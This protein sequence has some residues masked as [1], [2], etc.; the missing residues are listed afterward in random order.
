MVC[1]QEPPL[2]N[3]RAPK[4]ATK[5]QI[6]TVQEAGNPSHRCKIVKTWRTAEGI[7]AYQ[8][9]ALDTGEMMTIVESGPDRILKGSQPGTRSHAIKMR[10]FHW[11]NDSIPP[12]GSPVPP[13]Q[14]SKTPGL[15]DSQITSDPG[16]S[17]QKP[18]TVCASK[19]TMLEPAKP[20]KRDQNKI[21]LTRPF[22]I[23]STATTAGSANKSTATVASQSAGSNYA[24][25]PSE[26]S[27]SQSSWIPRFTPP[28]APSTKTCETTTVPASMPGVA[29]VA[30]S[31]VP[32]FDTSAEVKPPILSDC[33]PSQSTWMPQFLPPKTAKTCET[34]VTVPAPVSSPVPTVTSTASFDAPKCAINAE[35][36]PPISSTVAIAKPAAAI[37][38]P[39]AFATGSNANVFIPTNPPQTT[40]SL[41]PPVSFNKQ[42]DS[43]PAKLSMPALVKTEEPK[44]V[45]VSAA[46]KKALPE[47]IIKTAAPAI[48][49]KQTDPLQNPAGYTDIPKEMAR[50]ESTCIPEPDR[51][52]WFARWREQ[53]ETAKATQISTEE[54][55]TSEKV[56]TIIVENQEAAPRGALRRLLAAKSKVMETPN[57]KET[58]STTDVAEGEIPIPPV[59]L[60]DTSKA[61]KP[62]QPIVNQNAGYAGYSVMQPTVQISAPSPV[63]PEP[64]MAN[65][66]TPKP[67]PQPAPVH[68]ALANAFTSAPRSRSVPPI[69]VYAPKEAQPTMLARVPAATSG[70]D[71]L[72]SL[73]SETEMRTLQASFHSSAGPMQP[74]SD[75]A[76]QQLSVLKN[77]LYPSQREWAVV[78]LASLDWHTHPQVLGGLLAAS[79]EDP[80]GT[81]RAACVR[82]LAKMQANTND[83]RNTLRAL[84]NDNDPRVRLEVE[85]VL[86]ALNSK[87]ATG[88][89]HVASPGL[90][91]KP[92]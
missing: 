43:L 66:F 13:E 54:P 28:K 65:A 50:V 84:R 27:P 71:S 90:A 29:S 67:E 41:A 30:S 80:A 15:L 10:I 45:P 56:E 81:V 31:S 2:S 32:K 34:T 53:R 33:S 72:P 48:P 19:E 92:H 78:S 18:T 60:P 62:P 25:I 39:V 4:K 79:R 42:M 8:V 20:L 26:R 61:P 14:V 3:S 38:S 69:P 21:F 40:A 59:E 37:P 23:D 58:A 47:V 63:K 74:K 64:A 82:S 89:N 73:E 52:S 75:V 76:T 12:Q 85:Q 17:P 9:R 87:P 11:A 88:M 6:V 46:K 36:K 49:D 44:P 51:R 70:P 35:V 16:R 77:S 83:V 24:I 57:Q 7:K 68:D 5:E 91:G 55:S 22:P 1:A 86:A